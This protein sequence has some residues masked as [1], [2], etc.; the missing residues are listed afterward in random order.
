MNDRAFY[1]AFL[2]GLFFLRR[3]LCRNVLFTAH[4]LRDNIP[5]NIFASGGS[6]LYEQTC[7]NRHPCVHPRPRAQRNRSGAHQ[8]TE[9]DPRFLYGHEEHGNL[10]RPERQAPERKNNVAHI[11][12]EQ[13]IGDDFIFDEIMAEMDKLELDD[14]E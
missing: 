2:R 11:P 6:C 8:K 5:Q 3:G 1:F 14:E 7:N 10:H 13:V 9:P 12:L 4:H